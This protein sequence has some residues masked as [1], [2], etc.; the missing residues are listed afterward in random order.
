MRILIIED[1]REQCTL[2]QFRL[3]KEGY[4]SDICF[5]GA[6][7]DYYLSSNAYDLVLLDCMLPHKDGLT[8]LSE[9]RRGGNTTP[10][11]ML[12]ALGEL[13]DRISGLDSGADDYIV[14]PYE[15]GELMARIRC[16]LR[17]HSG[18]ESLS[19]LKAGDV[20]YSAAEKVLTG[21][22]DSCT[23]SNKEG[24]LMELFLRNPDQTLSRS[25][26]LS[27]IWGA[28]YEIEGGN[29]DNYIYFVRRRLR[30][31]GSS[32][33]IKTVHGIGYRLSTEG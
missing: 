25:T 6:D 2:L 12:T 4:S 30:K 1:D 7:A 20:E 16:R 27:R 17:R 11:I 13:S 8:I 18:I 28:D 33:A 15:F 21:P 32:L 23:L 10:V 31:V 29:L 22:S 19:R 26:I 5:D 9:M 24:E 14:K 3:E